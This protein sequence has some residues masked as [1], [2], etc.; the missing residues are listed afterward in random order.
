[1]CEKDVL[2]FLIFY[3]MNRFFFHGQLI[4]TVLGE[5]PLVVTQYGCFFYEL[6]FVS[7]RRGP[8]D[9]VGFI[10]EFPRWRVAGF[11]RTSS[12]RRI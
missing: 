7:F 9:S 8:V 2:Y 3:A 11:T 1:M 10:R 6:V 12:M 4:I 5:R